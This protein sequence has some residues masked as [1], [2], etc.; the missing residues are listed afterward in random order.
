[1]IIFKIQAKKSS[2]PVPEDEDLVLKACYLSYLHFPKSITLAM[3]H[4]VR[5]ILSK[6]P[7]TLIW[8]L[9]FILSQ[10]SFLDKTHL[11]A[12][13]EHIQNE[14]C[15]PGF[16]RT[17]NPFKQWCC[18]VNLFL[19]GVRRYGADGSKRNL[20]LERS[21]PNPTRS[22]QER[23]INTSHTTLMINEA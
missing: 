22:W 14:C 19:Q 12:L 10:W 11:F 1:M 21:V 23:V 4:A 7:G 16:C 8:P 3:N 6:K 13:T 17:I 9:C 2:T 15:L 20:W 18:L 5:F